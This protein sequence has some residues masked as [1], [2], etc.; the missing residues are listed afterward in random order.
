MTAQ[1]VT[2]QGSIMSKDTLLCVGR[3][4]LVEGSSDGGHTKAAAS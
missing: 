4:T 1:C 3:S 2:V